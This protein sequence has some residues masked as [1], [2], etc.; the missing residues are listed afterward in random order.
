[1]IEE[2]FQELLKQLKEDKYDNRELIQQVLE[3]RATW[4]SRD[5]NEKENEK[6]KRNK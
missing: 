1:M 5:S 6:E 3:L 4:R 2:A